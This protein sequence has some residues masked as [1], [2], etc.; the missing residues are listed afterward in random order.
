MVGNTID[1]K[2]E[3][4]ETSTRAISPYFLSTNDNPGNI[5]TQVHLKGDNYDDE[6]E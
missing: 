3:G 6:Q 4:N 1:G 5:I 2:K